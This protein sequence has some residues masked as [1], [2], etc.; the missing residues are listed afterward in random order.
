VATPT[1]FGLFPPTGHQSTKTIYDPHCIF[2]HF[3]LLIPHLSHFPKSHFPIWLVIDELYPLPAP[4]S[5]QPFL[6]HHHHHHHHRVLLP[7]FFP[8]LILMI[9]GW[10]GAFAA[11]LPHIIISQ[12]SHSSTPLLSSGQSTFFLS[13]LQSLNLFLISLIGF[14]FMGHFYFLLSFSDSF[15]DQPTDW[16]SLMALIRRANID[17]QEE[18]GTGEREKQQKKD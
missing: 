8:N 10:V 15:A 6:I 3:H 18:K 16:T 5:S 2:K 11:S 17:Q 13:F 1:A 12:H 4:H 14:V 9:D 7:Q